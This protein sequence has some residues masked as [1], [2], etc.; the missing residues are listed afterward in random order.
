MRAEEASVQTVYNIL[1][2]LGDA[3]IGRLRKLCRTPGL[4]MKAR[5]EVS[6]LTA[7]A[8]RAKKILIEGLEYHEHDGHDMPKRVARNALIAMGVPEEEQP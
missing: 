2:K 4:P 5:G 7:G 3:D 6:K 1:D 8:E